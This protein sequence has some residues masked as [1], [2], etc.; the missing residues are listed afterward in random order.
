MATKT[1]LAGR[2]TY[3]R[4]QGI[5]LSNNQGYRDTD[6][7][8]I[9]DGYEGTDFIVLSDHNR[10]PL[11]LTNTRIESRR[12]M[13][14]GT[15]RSYFTADKANLSISWNLLPSRSFSDNVARSDDGLIVPPRPPAELP[16]EYTV[17]GGAGGVDLK[18]WHDDHPGPFFVFL[19]Y[20]RYDKMYTDVYNK[21]D[22]YND[23]LHMYFSSFDW[24]VET[25]HT[26]ELW[27]VSLNLEEV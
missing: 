14:N 6:G 7:S 27:N 16:H 1:Y 25:R 9:P 8:Y 24:S 13:V 19:A 4:P 3:A 23:R 21:L 15:M 17:D 18:K 11:S 22:K 10:S 26:C 20:D 12:R 5:L 2:K